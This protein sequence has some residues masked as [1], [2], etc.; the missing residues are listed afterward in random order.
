M[1]A[2]IENIRLLL[3]D[4]RAELMDKPNVSAT[5]I[6]WKITNGQVTDTLAL[7]CSVESKQA[8]ENLLE[9]EQ[10]PLSIQDI[11]TDVRVTGPIRALQDL[12]RKFR[13][14]A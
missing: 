8:K 3:S 13:R 6:G 10:I 14:A 4:V 9:S 12:R 2:Q 7:V 1:Q 5:G 11:P